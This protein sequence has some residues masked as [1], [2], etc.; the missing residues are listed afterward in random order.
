MYSHFKKVLSSYKTR[1]LFY[2]FKQMEQLKNMTQIKIV[3]KHLYNI[4]KL[5]YNCLERDKSI[6]Y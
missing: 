2:A 3:Y 1:T 5:W 4:N 6:E